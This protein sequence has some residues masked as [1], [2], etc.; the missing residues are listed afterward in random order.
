MQT[1]QKPVWTG[2]ILWLSWTDI[3]T[4]CLLT[5]VHWSRRP[6]S[7][8]LLNCSGSRL[9]LLIKLCLFLCHY[10][11]YFFQLVLHPHIMAHSRLCTGVRKINADVLIT[12]HLRLEHQS[13]TPHCLAS[14]KCRGQRKISSDRKHLCE[15][16]F[17]KILKHNTV[18][19]IDLIIVISCTNH[20][21]KW[22]YT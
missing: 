8:F 4:R 3:A 15:R 1:R 16:P 10:F 17:S 18:C 7:I 21:K 14:Q 11:I 22:M 9:R 5:R 20:L 13:H 6:T 19:E 12:H 2:P